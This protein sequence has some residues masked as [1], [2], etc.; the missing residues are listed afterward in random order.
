[1]KKGILGLALITT[2]IAITSCNVEYVANRYQVEV[3]YLNNEFVEPLHTSVLLTLYS[4]KNKQEDAKTVEYLEKEQSNFSSM[5]KDV[6]MKFDR[7]H[8]YDVSNIKTIND[9]YGTNNVIEIDDGL[10]YVLQTGIEMTSLTNGYFNIGMGTIIDAWGDKFDIP[11]LIG[12]DID[13]NTLNY[14]LANVPTVEEV[15]NMLTF[16]ENGV[17]F[18]K[19]DNKNVVIS[20]GGISKGY[21][22]DYTSNY[23]KDIKESALISCGSSSIATVNDNPIRGTWNIGLRLP[24]IDYFQTKMA[25]TISLKGSNN[26][27]CSADNEKNFIKNNEDGTT[28]VRHHILNPYTGY[29][30]N[31]HRQVFL[32]SSNTSG[33]VLDALSTALMNVESIEDIK[34]IVSNVEDYYN[35]TIEFCVFNDSQANNKFDIYITNNLNNSIYVSEQGSS[36]SDDIVN[37]T[38]I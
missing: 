34:A 25:M 17:I 18:N 37:I 24:I 8:N 6:H 38:I 32:S 30:E 36:L 5:I 16:T 7:D 27:S 35:S 22:I 11:G 29:P 28:T 12:T 26:L 33:T 23:L 14:A 2:C 31:Y 9:S 21:A 15:S 20:L 13:E 19:V 3:F 4:D 10:R 1:M